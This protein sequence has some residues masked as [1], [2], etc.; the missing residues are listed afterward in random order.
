M[1]LNVKWNTKTFLRHC[2]FTCSLDR[3]LQIL[4]LIFQACYERHLY[5]VV[6]ISKNQLASVTLASLLLLELSND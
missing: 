3:T 2:N 5:G 1:L 6:V 4:A